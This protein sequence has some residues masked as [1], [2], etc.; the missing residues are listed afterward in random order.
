M[1]FYA[2]RKFLTTLIL[3]CAL[4]GVATAGYFAIPAFQ[5]NAQLLTKNSTAAILNDAQCVAQGNVGISANGTLVGSG[6]NGQQP[7]TVTIP[8]AQTPYFCF[9]VI[10]L[11][12]V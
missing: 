8:L 10:F 6:N 7:F 4:V 9:L 3:A 1:P 11:N 12:C 2:S 5:K